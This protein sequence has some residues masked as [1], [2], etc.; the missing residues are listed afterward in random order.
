MG[1]MIACSSTILL[2]VMGIAIIHNSS[3][4]ISEGENY[5]RN[6]MMVIFGATL[7]VCSGCANKMLD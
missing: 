6:M 4:S 3:K 7:L 2:M 5:Q 1:Y